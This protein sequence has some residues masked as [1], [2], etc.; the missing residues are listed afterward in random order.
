MNN[1][2]KGHCVTITPQGKQSEYSA[3]TALRTQM[4]SITKKIA[5]CF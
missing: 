2:S 5:R 3:V 4:F 1:A